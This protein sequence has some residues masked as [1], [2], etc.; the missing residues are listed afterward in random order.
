[1]FPLPSYQQHPTTCLSHIQFGQ[2]LTVGGGDVGGYIWG[3]WGVSREE[4]MLSILFIE[5]PLGGSVN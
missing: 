2:S 4:V 1:M 5:G 3:Q